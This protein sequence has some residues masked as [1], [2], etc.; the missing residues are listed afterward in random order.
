MEDILKR[1]RNWNTRTNDI[2]RRLLLIALVLLS[3]LVLVKLLPLCWPFVLALLFAMLMEPVVRLLRRAFAKMSFGKNIATILTMVVLFGLLGW[4]LR[5]LIGRLIEELLS[6]ARATPY[7]WQMLSNQVTSWVTDLSAKY[8]DVLP[9][10]AMEIMTTSLQE[11]GKTLRDVAFS[12]SRTVASG[13]W[14]TAMSVPTMLLSV[15][16]TIMATYYLSSDRERIF[17][18]FHRTFP[19]GMIRKGVVLKHDLFKALIGQIRAQLLVSLWAAARPAYRADGRA[20]RSGRWAV[21]DPLV[22]C[23]LCDRGYGHGCWHGAFVP[24]CDRRPAGG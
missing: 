6:L 13:A 12:I 20:A 19:P 17:A 15:V 4:G 1:L 14:A 5:V 21:F 11:A 8:K 9:P 2:P 18:F 7:L 3:C 22:P 23:G 24:G 16:L 10:D